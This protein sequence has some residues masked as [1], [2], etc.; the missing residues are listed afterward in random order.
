MA[1]IIPFN[2]DFGQKD[3]DAKSGLT[4]ESIKNSKKGFDIGD[5][6]M[7]SFLGVFLVKATATI[8]SGVGMALFFVLMWLKPLVCGILNLATGLFL[9]F[10]IVFYFLPKLHNHYHELLIASF[11]FFLLSWGYESLIMKLS[12]GDIVRIL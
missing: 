6:P 4:S 12:S 8:A 1:N 9:I 5:H 11:V 7:L 2:K 3:V 10:G